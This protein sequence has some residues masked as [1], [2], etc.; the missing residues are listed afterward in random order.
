VPSVSHHPWMCCFI[1]ALAISLGGPY[2]LHAEQA[3]SGFALGVAA[4]DVTATSA[5]LWTRAEE[6][7]WIDV[8][9][10]TDPQLAAVVAT[11]SA[12]AVPQ[13]DLTVKIVAE[14]LQP[15]TRYYY[16]FARRD[17]PSV[18]SRIGTFVAAP[19][20]TDPQ[21][22]VFAFSGDSN[23]L[24]QPFL[25][26]QSIT[27]DEPDFFIY[28]GD[29]IYADMSGP[30]AQDLASFRGKYRENRG[31]PCLQ[32]LLAS[33][34]VWCMWDDH[35]VANDYFGTEDPA[36]AEFV[37]EA[38]QAFFEYMPITPSAEFRTFRRVR[39]GALA[40][41]F[42]LDCRQFRSP[43]AEGACEGASDPLGFLGPTGGDECLEAI[44]APDR[45]ML[46]PDQLGWLLDGLKNSDAKYKFII[47]S[48]PMLTL[49][50]LPYD[51]WDGFAA[52]RL[53]IF[54]FIAENEI[55]NVFIISADAHLNAFT[56]DTTR[57]LKRR[58]LADLPADVRIPECV[59]GPIAT[60]TFKAEV[61]EAAPEML[62]LPGDA[63]LVRL[64]FEFLFDAAMAEVRDLN[65]LAF[66]DPDRFAYLLVHVGPDRV[67]FEFKGIRPETI[68]PQ[69]ARRLFR[70]TVGEPQ[71]LPCVLFALPG[72][73]AMVGL[74]RR[75]TIRA[76]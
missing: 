75:L 44:N 53:A 54:T 71:G 59:A 41:F 26:L 49:G 67:D 11:L 37:F 13:S 72:M 39:Y 6:P 62:G 14:Q 27:D 29:T 23:A 31:D 12:E 10:A 55:E 18:T 36:V 32:D 60:A 65:D 2:P 38:Y 20:E 73:I 70:A 64:L 48:V 15:A 61:L 17:D 51:R 3:G 56:R 74:V 9:I 47:S 8:E 1:G 68:D 66:L 46:G 25:L 33:T 22:F 69:P 35:E 30:V 34:A 28:C 45:T 57:H 76:A 19:P 43:S 7:G 21:E 50:L 58:S 42:F 63:F 16:R 40:E 24:Y 52:E 4:G 5:V